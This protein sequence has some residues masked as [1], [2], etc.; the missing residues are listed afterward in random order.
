M[1]IGS[2]HKSWIC[3]YSAT[4][5]DPE[6]PKTLPNHQVIQIVTSKKRGPIIAMLAD[7]YLLGTRNRCRADVQCKSWWLAV[8][9]NIER[10]GS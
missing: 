8:D 3:S 9:N 5:F 10:L 2:L 4:Q 1:T 6:Y 7:E